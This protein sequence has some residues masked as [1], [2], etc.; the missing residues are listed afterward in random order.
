MVSDIDMRINFTVIVVSSTNTA[1][2]VIITCFDSIS[3][4]IIL[5]TTVPY[6]F[7][8]PQCFSDGQL[9][10]RRNLQGQYNVL[11]PVIYHQLRI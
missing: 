11:A 2:G 3:I 8:K 4:P 6:Y 5:W 9:L 7:I 1:K 10:K